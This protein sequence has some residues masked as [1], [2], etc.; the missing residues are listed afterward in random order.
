MTNRMKVN[1][2]VSMLTEIGVKVS[3]TK[4]RVDIRKSIPQMNVEKLKLD[5]I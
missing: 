3:K 1:H 4:S 2:I 5:R